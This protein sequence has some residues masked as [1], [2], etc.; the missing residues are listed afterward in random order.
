[1]YYTFQLKNGEKLK[2]F[3]QDILD[4]SINDTYGYVSF[5][6]GSE[7]NIRSISEL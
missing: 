3:Y 7:K 2:V 5:W 4:H 6:K 1:M